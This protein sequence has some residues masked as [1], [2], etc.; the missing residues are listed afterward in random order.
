[1]PWAQSAVVPYGFRRV[2]AVCSVRSFGISSACAPARQ[3]SWSY[4]FGMP[5]S[6]IPRETSGARSSRARTRPFGTTSSSRQT[7]PHAFRRGTDLRPIDVINERARGYRGRRE[8]SMS[9]RFVVVR[10]LKRNQRDCAPGTGFRSPAVLP[11]RQGYCTGR[12]SSS[13][14]RGSRPVPSGARNVPRLAERIPGRGSRLP[15]SFVRPL[16]SPRRAG[17]HGAGREVTKNGFS[18]MSAFCWGI[19][20]TATVGHVLGEVVRPPPPS[21]PVPRARCRGSMRWRVL[22]HLSGR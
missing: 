10:M 8:K 11:P 4:A 22:H 21:S 20:S 18:G 7:I 13:R 16:Q 6:S 9:L 14:R 1:M 12:S 3:A 5:E 15:L 17:M 2:D 19:Q